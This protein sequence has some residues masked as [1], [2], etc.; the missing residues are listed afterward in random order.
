MYGLSSDAEEFVPAHSRI[1]SEQKIPP[2]F[3]LH[4]NE[5]NKVFLNN[6]NKKV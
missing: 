2:T 4:E 1:L 5:H 6:G 3:T